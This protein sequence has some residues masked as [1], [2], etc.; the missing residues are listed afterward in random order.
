MN[1][2]QKTW[3]DDEDTQ[4]LIEYFVNENILFK[5]EKFPREKIEEQ[6]KKDEYTIETFAKLNKAD[7]ANLED[8]KL[9]A[10]FKKKE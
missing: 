10:F 9:N 1:Y 7:F 5:I 8:K 4:I 3:N 6:D 2:I